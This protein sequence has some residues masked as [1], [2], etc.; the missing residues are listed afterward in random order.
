M[1]TISY[2]DELTN[3]IEDDLAKYVD[4]MNEQ[5]QRIADML[6]DAASGFFGFI[7]DIFSDTVDDA[8]D[9]WNNEILP[10]IQT[11]TQQIFTNVRDAV[12]DLAGRPMDLIAYA[13]YFSD[14][15]ATIYQ[16]GDLNQKMAIFNHDWQGYAADNY[17]AVATTEDTGFLNLSLAMD[18][19]ATLTTAAANQI[20]TLWRKLAR[21]FLG[22]IGD[23]IGCFEKATEADAIL[24]FE[25]PAA[26]DLAKAIWN[27]IAD[28]ADILV[29]FLINQAT[30]AATSWQQLASGARGL[31]QNKWPMVEEANS[32]VMNDPG[33]WTPRT[34]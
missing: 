3:G 10:W 33:N 32:D 16:P 21:E 7:A 28:L 12:G 15:K 30:T 26:F 1:S 29:E 31:P 8:I 4:E 9:R 23:F 19:G 25:L 5:I 27:N 6:N 17:K 11:T 2:Y 18:A 14:V 13:G 24:S 20:L 22:W 34:A